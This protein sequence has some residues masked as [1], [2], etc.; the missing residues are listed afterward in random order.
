MRDG[1]CLFCDHF[2]GA[3][4]EAKNQGLHLHVVRSLLNLAATYGQ[5]R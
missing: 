2:L 4:F 5:E 1:S 3:F